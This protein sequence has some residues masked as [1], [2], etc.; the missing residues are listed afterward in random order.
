MYH[1]TDPRAALA[2]TWFFRTKPAATQFAGAEYAKLDETRGATHGARTWYACNNFIIAYS[3]ADKGAAL[4]QPA[5]WPTYAPR[6]FPIPA[7]EIGAGNERKTVSGHSISF[8][9][10]GAS[11]IT[12]LGA[13]KGGSH[14]DDAIGRDLAK[15]CSQRGCNL[16]AHSRRRS[17]SRGRRRAGVQK[18]VPTVLMSRRRPAGSAASSVAPLSR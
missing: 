16:R 7:R 9:P 15:L 17:S 18:S 1:S 12:L 14:D 11:S 3:D 5:D 10:A 8:V 4:S 13:A 6:R 2:A